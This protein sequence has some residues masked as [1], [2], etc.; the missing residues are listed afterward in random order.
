MRVGGLE[1]MD[2]DGETEVKPEGKIRRATL[3]FRQDRART[4][5]KDVQTAEQAWLRGNMR[6]NNT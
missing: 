6:L 1:V 4:T 3:R 5:G 2:G